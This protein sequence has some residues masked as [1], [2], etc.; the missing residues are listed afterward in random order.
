MVV[1]TL[2]L[3]TVRLR[4]ELLYMRQAKDMTLFQITHQELFY[5]NRTNPELGIR[6]LIVLK[7][8]VMSEMMTTF[9][10]SILLTLI[11]FAT[12]LFKPI[13]FE[14]SLSVNLT[15]MLV[16][17][18]IFISKMEGLPPTSDTKMIDMWLILCQ[19]VPFIEV[20]LVTAIEFYKVDDPRE[21]NKEEDGEEMNMSMI[22]ADLYSAKMDMDI[23]VEKEEKE[24]SKDNKEEEVG[25]MSTNEVLKIL[26]TLREKH[27]K[28]GLIVPHLHFI[29]LIEGLFSQ[30]FFLTNLFSEEKI[31]PGAVVF[32]SLI[33]F[34]V[35]LVYYYED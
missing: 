35:A 9:F 5:M 11:T 19:L 7:R 22:L 15:T 28:E 14:A 3:K 26:N 25:V 31:V 16:M 20:M 4:P 33:Y 30:L 2:D 27:N 10:P 29:G 18:T 1:G 6:M 34:S 13:Y 12:T 23:P 17:T 21:N 32:L 24:E 8:K